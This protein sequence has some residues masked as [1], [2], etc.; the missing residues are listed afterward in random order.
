VFERPV[1]AATLIAAAK[2][3]LKV[4]RGQY[5]IRDLLLQQE[6]AVERIDL[7]AAVASHLLLSKTPQDIT[8][9]VFRQVAAHLGLD[10]YVC[11]LLEPGGKSLRLSSHLGLPES[12][13]AE[14]LVLDLHASF[15]GMVAR[16]RER[17]VQEAVQ[18]TTDPQLA[19]VRA[20]GINA[21]ACFPL[22]SNGRLIGTLSFGSRQCDHFE[23]EELAMLDT[24]CNE[25][26]VAIERKRTEEALQNLNEVL[27]KRVEERTARL[28]E[29]NEQM[30]AF[31]YSV[32][33]DLRAP[34]RAIRGFSQALAE[35]YASVLD[36][37]GRDYLRRMEEG[38]ERLDSLINDVLQYSRL[39]RSTLTFDPLNLEHCVRQALQPLE[40]EIAAAK[41]IIEVKSPLPS[42]L[43]H[44][45]TLQQV[46]SNLISNALKFVPPSVQPHV[47]IWS[48]SDARSVRLWVGDNGIGIAP[49][50]QQRIFGVFERLHS[51]EDYPGT[52][53]GLA[54]VAKGVARMNGTVGVESELG[55]GSRF[56]IELPKAPPS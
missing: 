7:L 51:H 17:E 16:R 23:H 34:L 22:L 9:T 43:G 4:R 12:V 10:L 14:R 8:A 15:C 29:I 55:Q 46:I 53:I 19:D 1:P 28:Q 36:S 45:A 26:A 3:A 49:T 2:L 25:I 52:G 24:L 40:S 35:D 50:Y 42:V 13:A 5:Q 30:E 39:G 38:A 11:Y 47:R 44:E 56:W 6:K 27:E 20:L 54:I 18:S 31:T 48:T 33:H 21:Y 37:T 41:A 32:S